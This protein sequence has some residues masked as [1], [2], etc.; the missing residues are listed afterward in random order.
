MTQNAINNKAEADFLVTTATAGTDR[1]LSVTNTDNSNAASHSHNQITTGGA[2]GGD[3]YT[4][5]LVTGA[6]TF[7]AGI[8]NSD[9]DKYKVT[10]GAT[11]SA[12]TE[13][14]TIN[15]SGV[16]SLPSQPIAV[17]YLSANII[18]VT[19]D[20]THYRPILFDAVVPGSSTDMKI[21]GADQGL[22]VA[23]N[24]GM[25]QITATLLLAPLD[26][27]DTAMQ[28]Y[29]WFNGANP[30]YLFGLNPYAICTSSSLRLTGSVTYGLAAGDK[31]GIGVAVGTGTKTV[32]VGGGV[33]TAGP[34]TLII[35]KIG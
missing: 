25:Y 32:G 19:G 17:A 18:N 12:G 33:L 1:K 11:T 4:N 8:D 24:A 2:A 16:V 35:E 13:A 5:Y 21:A 14:I 26:A 10:T 34:C 22:F 9:A 20:G 3:P 30:L 27:A 28:F 6:G 29:L 23:T 15:S 31:V 7:S